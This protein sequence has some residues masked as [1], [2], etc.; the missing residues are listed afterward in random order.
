MAQAVRVWMSLQ[1]RALVMREFRRE[2]IGTLLRI[3]SPAT[4]LR[5]VSAAPRGS[6]RAGGC[7][8]DS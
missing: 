3:R 4:L 1:A 5:A 7:Q 2:G 8:M 6:F